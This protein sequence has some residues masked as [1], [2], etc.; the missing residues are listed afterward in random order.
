M[1]L[2]SWLKS[3]RLL[4]LLKSL[5]LTLV[6]ILFILIALFLLSLLSTYELNPSVAV[7]SILVVIDY[8]SNIFPFLEVSK[9]L[10][11]FKFKHQYEENILHKQIIIKMSLCIIG[12]NL[13]KWTTV[14][15][16][17]LNFRKKKWRFFFPFYTLVFFCWEKKCRLKN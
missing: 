15:L 14:Y 16:T 9:W 4:R 1:R 8:N 5:R 12:R 17:Q 3:L 11:F 6:E 10:W 13:A 7:N 2:L